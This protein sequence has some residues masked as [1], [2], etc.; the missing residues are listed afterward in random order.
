MRAWIFGAALAA[1]TCLASSASADPAWKDGDPVPDGYHVERTSSD[2]ALA[3]GTAFMVPLST[4]PMAMLTIGPGAVPLLFP[5]VGPFV[6]IGTLGFSPLGAAL[7]SLLGLSQAAGVALFTWGV[8]TP[9]ARVVRDRV[10]APYFAPRG[11]HWEHY[12]PRPIIASGVTLIAA[13]WVAG[14]LMVAPWLETSPSN[15]GML[16]PVVGPVI[17]IGVL[18][19]ELR[20]SNGSFGAIL[21]LPLIMDAVVQGTG[22]GMV[23]GG[24]LHRSTY[25]AKDDASL[26]VQ[27]APGGPAGPLGL[28]LIGTF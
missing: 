26:H 11:S 3:A 20:G 1:G 14:A 2:A 8:I 28:S 27:L 24:A 10:E 12:D 7:L 21:M 17:Q 19:S 18:A 4:L 6:A 9:N 25:V 5:G 23:L 13:P 15:A 22:L 16:V